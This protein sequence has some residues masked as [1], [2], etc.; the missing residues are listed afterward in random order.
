MSYTF[1]LKLFILHLV[2][3]NK[4]LLRQVFCE[5][6]SVLGKQRKHKERERESK[7]SG[8]RQSKALESLLRDEGHFEGNSEITGTQSRCLKMGVM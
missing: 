7:A 6:K 8:V 5:S 3:L 2:Q 4:I 1:S